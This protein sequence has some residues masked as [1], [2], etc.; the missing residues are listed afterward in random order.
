MEDILREIETELLLS[1]F[2][3]NSLNKVKEITEEDVKIMIESVKNEGYALKFVP[4]ESYPL[5][6]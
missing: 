5:Q 3:Y 4:N 2:K 6:M 1:L